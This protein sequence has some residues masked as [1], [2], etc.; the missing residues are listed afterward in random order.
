MYGMVNKGI[1]ELVIHEY[2]KDKWTKILALANIQEQ[3]F[4]GM[5]SYHDEITYNLVG[6]ASEVLDISSE[7]ILERFGEY[8]ITYTASEGY[9]HLL[10]IAGDN[11][12][13]FLKN[14]DRLH[15]SVG[16]I[17]PKLK[18]PS[19]KCTNIENKSLTLH[20][21]TDRPG[22]ESM[23]VGLV[24]GLGHRFNTPCTVTLLESKTNGHDHNVFMIKWI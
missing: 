11:L 12:S 3:A 7:K 18:P 21:Y 8:W 23:V 9:G 10:D 16:H 24:K 6:A 19:F 20:H 1:A 13:D 22:L 15:S 14:L 4:I 17:M 2:G 5:E